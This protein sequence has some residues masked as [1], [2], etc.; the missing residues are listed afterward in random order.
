M[1]NSPVLSQKPNPDRSF[2]EVR[3]LV[4]VEV[5]AVIDAI[6]IAEGK[7]RTKVVNEWLRERAAREHRY[8]TLV[9]NASRGNPAITDSS[10]EL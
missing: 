9:V 3:P 2:V 6:A 10:A 4:P 1:D 8:A 7:D 5:V